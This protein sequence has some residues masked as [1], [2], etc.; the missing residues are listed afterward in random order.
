M[1]YMSLRNRISQ[2]IA[3]I[4]AGF[5]VWLGYLWQNETIS[6]ELF[7]GGVV[8]AGFIAVYIIGKIE[9]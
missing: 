6:L 8:V 3:M 4:W 9:E 2:V 7:L 5:S 1:N